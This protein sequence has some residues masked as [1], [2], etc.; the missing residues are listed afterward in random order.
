MLNIIL[1]VG[2]LLVLIILFLL[3]RISNLVTIVKK[4][5]EDKI[6]IGANKINAFLLLL[7]LIVSGSLFAW[8]SYTHFD[9]YT[10]P[11]ASEHGVL[12]DKLF[13]VTTAV[14]G[15]IFVI[16]Q[17]LLFT[18]PII[19][20]YK[21]G[22]RAYFY[23]DNHKL[24]LAW[25]IVPAIVLAIL[26][27]TGLKVWSDITDIAPEDSEVVEIMGQQFAWKLRYPGVDNNKLGNYDYRLTM[28]DNPMGVD[29][30]DVNSFDDFSPG[31]MYLPKGRNV[32]F[33]IR[34][35][36]VLHSVFAPHFRLKMDAVPG[37]PTSFW[38]TPTKTTEEMRV[39]TGNPDFNYEIACT[40][41]CGNGHFSMRLIVVVVEPDEFIEWK[42]NQQ[43]LIQRDPGLLKYVSQ[44]LKELALIKSGLNG[45]P[46]GEQQTVSDVNSAM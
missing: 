1:I 17:I 33:R 36:D 21:E 28:P 16:T 12:T 29:F 25:T 30:S 38:F 15:I 42:K 9:D 43:S 44:N 14:T 19:F 39:E 2:V 46:K 34:A 35:R 5:E 22:A 40:E 7:F 23:P 41:I 27:F 10:I 32:L 24:E 8:Y 31:Q 4:K 20:G 45:K 18:F 37:M 6:D 11:V 26:V 3:F 13:W